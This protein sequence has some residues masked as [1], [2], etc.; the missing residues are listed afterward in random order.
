MFTTILVASDGSDD[1]DRLV[2]VALRLARDGHSKVVVAHV[3]KLIA[4]RDVHY[5]VC[6]NEDRL[7][8]KVRHQVADLKAAGLDVELKLRSTFGATA[9]ALAEVAK[10]CGADLIVTGGG[11]HGRFLGVAFTGV[12]K[13]TGLSRLDAGRA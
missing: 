8:L 4:A 3:N 9:P 1:A 6:A 12:E 11:Q 13:R 10:D 7:Q 5:P 2:A